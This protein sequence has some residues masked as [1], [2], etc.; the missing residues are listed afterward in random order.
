MVLSVSDVYYINQFSNELAE[1]YP[2]NNHR[3]NFFLAV[4]QRVDYSVD[5]D[6]I[7]QDCPYG[8]IIG[9]GNSKLHKFLQ[10]SK[11]FRLHASLHDACGYMKSEFEIGP[12]YVYALKCNVSNCFIGHLSGITFCIYLKLFKRELYKNLVV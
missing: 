1:R 10:H 4:C 12:G 8:G 3:K 5:P 11:I 9:I 2:T 7:S 6:Y